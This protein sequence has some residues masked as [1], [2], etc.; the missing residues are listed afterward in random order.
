VRFNDPVWID[1]VTGA[2]YELPPAR[3]AIESGKTVLSDI[4]L[5]DA[6]TLI[7]DKSVVINSY[8]R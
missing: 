1:T 5:Y 3:C 2:I 8:N 4:P 6:P 7:T